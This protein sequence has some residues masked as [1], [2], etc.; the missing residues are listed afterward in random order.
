M[1]T[2]ENI[3]EA[4]YERSFL[5]RMQVYFD[6]PPEHC[7]WLIFHPHKKIKELATFFV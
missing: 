7:P 4:D 2:A 6:V 3:F 5:L 1:F